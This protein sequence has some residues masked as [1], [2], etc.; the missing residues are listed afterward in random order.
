MTQQFTTRYRSTM[1]AG[2]MYSPGQERETESLCL[3]IAVQ[4][5][6]LTFAVTDPASAGD[7]T[8]TIP[9][10]WGANVTLTYTADGAT[11]LANTGPEFAAVWNADPVFGKLY[12]ATAVGAVVTIVAQSTSL[13][14]PAASF[15]IVVPGT[16][17]L[18]AVQ[19]VAN[20][21]ASLRMGVLYRYST[22]T[23]VGPGITN[24][25]RQERPAMAL[26]AGTVLADI[27]GMVAREAN[28]TELS[29]TFV[30]TNPDQYTAPDIFPGLLRG[31]GAFV[32]DPA[33]ATITTAT[34]NV[35]AVIT[36]GTGTIPGAL[37]SQ[38]A[39]NVLVSA[40]SNLIRI[41]AAEET[42]VFGAPIQRMVRAKINQT[43]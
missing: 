39:G 5:L 42:Q 2:Q 10:P 1:A 4:Q 34:T 19:T 24:T 29:P 41:V 31:E 6:T 13:S 17:T 37:T 18:T 12:V 40:A 27:R 28:S 21:G 36:G 15:A 8:V 14:I 11:S 35:Y 38:A 33:S 23:S 20:G 16:T 26:G 25:F 43:L 30:E 7:Y 32:V 3:P 9:A 22:A